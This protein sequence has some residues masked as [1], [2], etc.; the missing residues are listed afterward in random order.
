[1]RFTTLS[2]YQDNS[3]SPRSPTTLGGVV[4]NSRLHSNSP[5]FDVEAVATSVLRSPKA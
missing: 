1:M 2:D 4:S 5:A 3:G